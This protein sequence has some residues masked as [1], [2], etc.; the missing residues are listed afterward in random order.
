V[1]SDQLTV[2]PNGGTLPFIS[3]NSDLTSQMINALTMGY[4]YYVDYNMQSGINQLS[5]VA[6]NLSTYMGS[7]ISGNLPV[8]PA[9]NFGALFAYYDAAFTTMWAM[10]QSLQA[11]VE[12]AGANASFIS[13]QKNFFFEY[14][15][16]PAHAIAMTLQQTNYI[17]DKATT[18]VGAQSSGAN[19]SFIRSEQSR[20]Q[21]MG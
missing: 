18:Q 6:C 14:T 2:P 4:D 20:I 11:A 10:E 3:Y 17:F 19:L 1:I 15:P 7:W 12:N 9:T 5:S 8:E 13:V 21:T 16:E